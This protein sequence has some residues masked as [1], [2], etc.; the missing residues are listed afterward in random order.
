[1]DQ[2]GVMGNPIQHSKSPFIHRLFAEQTSQ[3]LQYS[4]ILVPLEGLSDALKQF[5]DQGGKGVNIT[6]P[7]KHRAFSLVDSLSERA[8]RAEAINTIKFNE[9]GTRFGDNTDGA[10]IIRD[11]VSNLK[12]KIKNKRVLILGAGG[13]VRGI[14][15]PIL[16][17]QPIEVVLSN[18]S[19]SKAVAIAEEFSDRGPI[20]ACP[21]SLLEANAFDLVI[22]GTSA[23]LQGEMLDLPGSILNEGAL[24]YDMVYDKAATP[25]LRWA[26]DQDAA[27]CVDGIGML[28][29]QA[30]EAFY[31]WRDVKPNTKPVLAALNEMLAPAEEAVS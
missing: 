6:L 25:F 19:E 14:L 5:Q 24:C 18:R 28:V 2:Y 7:F 1:M 20:L 8:Q 21:L 23:S 17:E 31:V 26:K 9:D 11:I 29:E 15:D 12:F 10:G 16:N 13:A 30:A 4:P 3:Q 27:T 22:N